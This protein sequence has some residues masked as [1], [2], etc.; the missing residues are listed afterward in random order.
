MLKFSPAF[1]ERRSKILE[2][3]V[4]SAGTTVQE[5][6]EIAGHAVEANRDRG[7][8]EALHLA[9]RELGISTRRVAGILRGEVGRVW[10]DELETARRWHADY[11]ARK[12]ERLAHEASLFRA[13]ADAL[14]E[15]LG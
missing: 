1:L 2:R 11:C 12:A 10:A 9:A 5:M 8:A 4:G 15:R 7:H 14:R 13:R 3:A 6:R